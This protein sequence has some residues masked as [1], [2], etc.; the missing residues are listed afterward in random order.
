MSEILAQNQYLPFQPSF[1]PPWA[2]P[3]RS[4]LHKVGMGYK[5]IGKKLGDNC[6]CLYYFV[7]RNINEPSVTLGLELL[8]FLAA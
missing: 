7:A 1:Q 2:T 5:A 4:D 3:K 6:W 8:S